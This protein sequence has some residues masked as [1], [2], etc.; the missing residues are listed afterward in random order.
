MLGN[1]A[2]FA[3]SEFSLSVIAT[4]YSNSDE[5]IKLI[6]EPAA[7]S[8]KKEKERE[9]LKPI[10]EDWSSWTYLKVR[11]HHILSSL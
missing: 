9:S 10:K 4:H 7:S 8:L 6:A 5:S 1:C 2:E 3:T 11:G